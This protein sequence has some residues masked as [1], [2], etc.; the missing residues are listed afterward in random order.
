MGFHEQTR[1][2]PEIAAA[3]DAILFDPRSIEHRLITA[4]FPQRSRLVYA[5]VLFRRLFRQPGRLERAIDRLIAI[6]QQQL[7][8][9]L[10]EHMMLLDFP[11]GLR[12]RLG[13]DLRST[14]PAASNSYQPRSARCWRRSIPHPTAWSTLAR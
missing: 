4:L 2:Q 6:A 10:T 1:L 5:G 12:L 13:D 9:L 3:L 7:R 14:Y 11:G 8:T